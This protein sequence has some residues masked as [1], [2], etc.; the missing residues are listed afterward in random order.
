MISPVSRT[1]KPS[2]E[3]PSLTSI[4]FL[5]HLAQSRLYQ[6]VQEA[7]AGSGLHGGQ[8]AVLGALADKGE[9]SQRQLSEVA[10]IE[11]SSLVLFL[12]ALEAGGW[13]KRDADPQDRRA[14]R[15]RLTAKGAAKFHKLGP[16]LLAVQNRFLAPLSAAERVQLANLLQRLATGV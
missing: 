12:D 9:M 10:K 6:G 16:A 14:H 11:K 13:V 5:M 2:K 7:I 8:L 3:A 4:G 15:V 1:E